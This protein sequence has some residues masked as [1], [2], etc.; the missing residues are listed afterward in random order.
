MF[1]YDNEYTEADHRHEAD[2][3]ELAM[4]D[5]EARDMQEY[6]SPALQMRLNPIEERCCDNPLNFTFQAGIGRD[7]DTG[8]A[9]EDTYRCLGCGY[10]MCVEDYASLM[11]WESRPAT[12]KRDHHVEAA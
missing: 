3:A 6:P 9:D 12:T 7:P 8:Y 11:E 2:A 5:A 1:F 10:Q 4:L